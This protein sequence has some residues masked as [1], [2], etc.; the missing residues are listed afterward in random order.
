[1]TKKVQ[2]SIP[3]GLYIRALFL[4]AGLIKIKAAGLCLKINTSLLRL[5]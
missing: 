5:L 4:E 3:L 2:V 1:M